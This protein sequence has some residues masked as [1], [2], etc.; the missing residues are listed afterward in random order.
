MTH[1]CLP[2]SLLIEGIDFSANARVRAILD[3]PTLAPVVL[4]PG[5][6]DLSEAHERLPSDRR[7]V[8][9]V[10]DG[11]WPEAKKMM[12]RNPELAALPRVCFTPERP[13]E[14]RV[15]RQPRP[16]CV[17]TV[18]AIHAVLK[19]L[20]P[21]LNAEPLLELFRWRVAKQ[22]VY[23]EGRI[24]PRAVRGKRVPS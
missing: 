9:F 17:S 18:E 6:W 2:E 19:V 23:T 5:G 13:S 3:D 15:R 22:A 1:L 10:I 20:E 7:P 16:E 8:I 14:Y 12:N 21:E 24:S 4:Y 11:T